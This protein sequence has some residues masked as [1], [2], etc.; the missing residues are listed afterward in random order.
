MDQPYPDRTD[1]QT[2][3]DMSAACR[4]GT[5][6]HGVKGPSPLINLPGFSPAWSWCPDYMHCVLLGVSRQLTELWFSDTGTE[7]YCGMPSTM[8]L[9]NERLCKIR[10]PVCVSRQPRSLQVRKYWKASE[11]QYWLLHYSVLCLTDVLGEKYLTHWSLLVSG[12]FLLLKDS[13]SNADVDLSTQ[14]LT[15]FV[16]GVEFLYGRKNMTYNVHQ[17]LHL[18]KS[19]LLFGPL[20][21]H[22]CFTFETNM[23]RLLQLITSANGVALQV[24]TRLLLRSSLL[25]MKARASSHV[26]SLIQESSAKECLDS[27]TPLGKP[28]VVRDVSAHTQ[29]QEKEV[30]E[31]RRVKVR[32]AVIASERYSKHVRSNS[33]AVVLPDGT[34]ARAKRIFCSRE[35]SGEEHFYIITEAYSVDSILPSGHIKTARKQGHECLFMI[36]TQ[37]QPCI[38]FCFNNREYFCDFVNSYEWF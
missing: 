27:I 17:V 21:A 25:V 4:T 33:T 24:A 38:Y 10:M 11:W 15:E 31:F 35:S 22:S 32:G 9:I 26:L 14:L 37:T 23:G 2:L 36:D 13:I 12:V 29:L 1:E 19:A 18:P 20:W 8:R 6:V 7:Y 34:Y 5:I 30:V 28:E 3:A 16:V